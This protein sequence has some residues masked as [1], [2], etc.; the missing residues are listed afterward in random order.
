MA[1]SKVGGGLAPLGRVQGPPR[2]APLVDGAQ[3]PDASPAE[4]ADRGDPGAAETAR[5]RL[6]EQ[7]VA[8]R[9]GVHPAI[10]LRP[11]VSTREGRSCGKHV[12]NG[13]LTRL[14]DRSEGTMLPRA[15]VNKRQVHVP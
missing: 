8:Q 6:G 13:G 15:R 12:V 2:H 10:V 1:A 14:T 9:G 3:G 5:A 7:L 11:R 4:G